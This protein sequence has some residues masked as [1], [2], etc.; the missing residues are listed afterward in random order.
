MYRGG[1]RG[2]EKEANLSV[3][4]W[5]GHLDDG[6]NG[7]C[8]VG[9]DGHADGAVHLAW[10]SLVEGGDSEASGDGNGVSMARSLSTSASGER[11]M[12]A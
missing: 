12:A 11:D 10:C 6:S 8:T 9:G 2:G 4:I 5:V 3:W 1:G 7:E